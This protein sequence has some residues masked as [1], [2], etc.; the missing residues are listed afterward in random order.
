MNGDQSVAL[1][2]GLL[3]I[4]LVVLEFGRAEWKAVTR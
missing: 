3:L 4:A 2:L 1:F